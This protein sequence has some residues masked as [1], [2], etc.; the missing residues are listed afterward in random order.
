MEGWAEVYKGEGRCRKNRHDE[1]GTR[2][3]SREARVWD[4]EGNDAK[5]EEKE[6][7]LNREKSR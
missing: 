6:V 3:E 7:K 4:E 1:G 2:K 5:D